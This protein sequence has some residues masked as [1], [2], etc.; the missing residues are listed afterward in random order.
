MKH[1]SHPKRLVIL[2]YLTEGRKTVNEI[3]KLCEMSQSQT[4]QNLKRM[5]LEG[6]LVSRKEG[7]FNF[8]EIKD[9]RVTKLMKQIKS[10]F[11]CK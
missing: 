9:V 5:E 3:M 2:C 4:S 10:I 8:Y 7:N 1:M 11:C 6:V